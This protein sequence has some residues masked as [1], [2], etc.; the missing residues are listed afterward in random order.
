MTEPDQGV[1]ASGK[2]ESPGTASDNTESLTSFSQLQQDMETIK[3]QVRKTAEALSSS[4]ANQSTNQSG[5]DT[6]FR[7]MNDICSSG[8]FFILLGL[9]LLFF[10]WLGLTVGIHTSFSFV[11]VVLGIAVMLFG[12]GTQG[13]GRLTSAE[14]ASRYTISIAG[15]AGILAI[16]IGYGMVVLGPRIQEV[17]ELQTHYAWVELLADPRCSLGINK[18]WGE[19][20]A[21][22]Q[23]LAYKSQKGQLFVLL[24]YYYNELQ[25]AKIIGGAEDK[26]TIDT[27]F[28]KTIDAEFTVKDQQDLKNNLLCAPN[29]AGHIDIPVSELTLQNDSGFDF[30]KTPAHVF[31]LVNTDNPAAKILAAQ[32]YL[33]AA[34][35]PDAK[36]P[37]VQ[38]VPLPLSVSQ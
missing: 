25:R 6:F 34:A 22:G 7:R 11:L 36:P 28:K 15:G 30:K 27:E 29:A 35:H 3:Q 20:S 2:T 10:A 24:P 13:M 14:A 4:A 18:Y 1:P 23:P 32:P 31:N 9:G 8:I 38:N 26:K 5:F 16:A 33:P 21:D 17:F 37:D 19:F 12:T